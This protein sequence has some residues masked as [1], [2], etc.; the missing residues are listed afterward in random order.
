MPNR[1]SNL[2]ADLPRQLPQ[3]LVETLL[4]T[5]SFKIVQIVSDG[6]ASP[7]GFWYDQEM[8]EWVLLVGGSARLRFEGEE[9]IDMSPG[10]FVHIPAHQRHRV[11]A[12]DPAV[13]GLVG[14]LLFHLKRFQGWVVFSPAAS[15]SLFSSSAFGLSTC[16][17]AWHCSS[18]LSR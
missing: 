11:E 10:S 8:H 5:V 1:S 16:A 9:P 14:N 17:R 7:E 4:S 6:H 2:F 12:T 3:E 15:I 13:D 18:A